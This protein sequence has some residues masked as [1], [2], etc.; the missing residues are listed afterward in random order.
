MST[1]DKAFIDAYKTSRTRRQRMSGVSGPDY[2][3]DAAEAATGEAVVYDTFVGTSEV[4]SATASTLRLDGSH[5]EQ[6][7]GPPHNPPTHK[8]LASPT[9]QTVFGLGKSG[10]VRRPLSA[11]RAER[12]GQAFGDAGE[13]DIP[14]I[15]TPAVAKRTGGNIFEPAG[16]SWPEECQQLLAAAADK[17][18]A[19]LR[20]LPSSSCGLLIGMVGDAAESGCTTSAIC[21]ALRSAALGYSTAL[22]DGDLT[23]PCLAKTLHHTSY[24]SWAELLSSGQS[25]SSA[26]ESTGEGDVDLLLAGPAST[27]ELEAPA[28]FR[29][30]LAAGLLRRKYQRVIID[31]GCPSTSNTSLA[32]ELAAAMGVDFLFATTAPTSPTEQMTSTCS[33]LAEHNL[34]IAGILQA[35]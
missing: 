20:M 18:D 11:V 33:L 25:I 6:L 8:P 17:Y 19:V 1:T 31:L 2:G 35:A 15:N 5:E 16:A 9:P 32:A 10:S 24:T 7:P 27:G 13:T 28:G 23:H 30:S 14:E 34:E 4:V 22:V 21:L 12:A 3:A 29:A 26:I